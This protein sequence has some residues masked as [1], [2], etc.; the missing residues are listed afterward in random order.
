MSKRRIA[1][2]ALSGVALLGAQAALPAPV[3]A[4]AVV[5][6]DVAP[7]VSSH[8]SGRYVGTQSVTLTAAAGTEVRFTLDG[9]HPTRDSALASGPIQIERTA[10]LTA[11]AFT[12]R[13]ESRPMIRGILV[14]TAE[15]PLAQFAV[16][17]DIHLSTGTGPAMAKWDGYFD[18]LRRIAP[19][20]DALISNGDQIND[21]YFNSAADHQYPRA[22][23]ERNLARTGMTDTRVMMSFGN[24]DDYVTRMAE[25][26]PEEWFPG[27]TGYYES[28]IGEFPAFVVNTEAW[29]S[30]Q[31]SWL[32][33]RLGALSADPATQGQPVF[34]FGHRPIP[35]TVWDGAQASNGGLKST[36]SAFPQV[37]YFSGHSHLNITDERS[38]HQ[39]D[40]TSVN[41]GSMSYGENDGKFQAFGSGLARDATIPTAQSVVVDVYGDR[42]EIDRINYAADPGRTYTDDGTWAFQ[43]NPP[44]ASSGSLA[45]PSWV[46]A[47]G[48]TPAETKGQ[49]TYTQANRNRVAPGWGEPQPTVRQ[50]A[51]GPVLRLPQAGDDQFTAEYTLTVTDVQTGQVTDLVP[52]NGRI[53]SDYVVAPKP[54]VLDIPLAVRAGNRVGQPIDRALTI[55]REYEA[56][57]VAYDSY[58]NQSAPRSFRFVAGALDEAAHA[59]ANERADA[60][61]AR[62]ERVLGVVTPAQDADFGVVI[63]DV[64]AAE[65]AVAELRAQQASE[66]ATQDEV[67]ALA[68]AIADGTAA[69]EQRLVTVDRG[70][71]TAAIAEVETALG[72][73]RMASADPASAERALRAELAAA[74]ELRDTLNVSQTQLD[75]ATEELRAAHAAWRDAGETEQPGTGEPGKPAEPGNPDGS[76]VAGPGGGSASGG[77]AAGEQLAQTGAAGLPVLAAA[78]VLLVAGAAALGLR[79][80]AKRA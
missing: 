76:G 35:A 18:T 16:M 1:A 12:E 33:G 42:I 26:Y 67:D 7:P 41:E 30:T 24:H 32:S 39:Q 55:G 10:N 70:A 6:G 43:E 51:D 54:A 4:N 66:A 28:K 27:T 63:A 60:A 23:L 56:T 21:N 46:I 79:R 71:L 59:A 2:L 68:W 13:A 62:V 72:V 19:S 17:S 44:F 80:R 3:A 53:Y 15:E 40:F 65:A 25:Q 36:L 58:Q 38:I 22:M 49:F 69:L 5:S 73:T 8:E 45:G 47:R 77:A 34:V 78:G 61:I 31:A 11:V 64:P 74:M 14:K 52:A 57:L 29:N 50:T 48:A 75:T 9:T 37:V 20:P